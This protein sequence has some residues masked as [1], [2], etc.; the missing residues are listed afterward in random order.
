MK[1]MGRTRKKI[2]FWTAVVV[3][4][5][6]G[7]VGYLTMG[8]Q[9][10]L[11]ARQEILPGVV[12]VKDGFVGIGII[13]AG[14]GR[15]VLIDAGNDA[16]GK[17]ILGEMAKRGLKVGD[18]S[19]I[20]LTHGHPDHRRGVALFPRSAVYILAADADLA[21]GKASPK[22]PLPRLLP[23]GDDHVRI[24]RPLHD[25]ETVK[26]GAVAVR[27]FELPGHTAGSAAYLA[28]GALF[29]GDAAMISPAGKLL[30]PKWIFSDDAEQGRR[31]LAILAHRLL[32]DPSVKAIVTSHAGALVS[33]LVPL[34]D[35]AAGR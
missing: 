33:G 6:F 9:Q 27:V 26:V 19:A 31:S 2:V 21:V 23:N 18:V 20:F 3:V 32:G 30:G 7:T 4:I 16:A 10:A 13:E 11:P 5:L 24:T 28:G 12:Q 17:V 8:G 35:F 25:G 34:E 1:S 22:G 14:H 15:V 29:L